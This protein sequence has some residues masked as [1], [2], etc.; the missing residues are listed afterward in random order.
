MRKIRIT[1][2]PV[3]ATIDVI[4]GKWKPLILYYLKEGPLRFG[5]LRRLMDGATQKVLT[6]Q[7][8]ELERADIVR[9]KAYAQVLPHRVEY[10]LSA[11]GETLRPVLNSMCDW[12]IKHRAR[13]AD[14]SAG[15][16]IAPAGATPVPPSAR[17]PARGSDER[18]RA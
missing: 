13:E 4:A 18:E 10:S 16:L 9:R 3:K 2:C 1:E 8:R 11:Y 17:T 12:G 7:L 14:R 6:A 15:V 5:E